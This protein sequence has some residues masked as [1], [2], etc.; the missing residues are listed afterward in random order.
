MRT[1]NIKKKEIELDLNLLIEGKGEAKIEGIGRIPFF[2]HLLTVLV[3]NSLFDLEI[4]VK[5]KPFQE[6]VYDVGIAL[7][8]GLNEALGDR[9]GLRRYGY[10]VLPMDETLVMVAL[11]I[12]GKPNVFIAG[13][14]PLNEIVDNFDISLTEEFLKA[15]VNNA[16]FTLHIIVLYGKDSHH[17]FEAIFKGMGKALRQA[18]EF[19]DR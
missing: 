18:C 3:Y 1:S 14:K 7:G 17:I 15:F 4:S 12:G 13:I 2:S 16:M 11:D 6:I 9:K 5:G 19:D 10:V 8:S